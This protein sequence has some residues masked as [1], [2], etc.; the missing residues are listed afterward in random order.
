MPE[1]SVGSRLTLL[2]R[3]VKQLLELVKSLDAAMRFPEESPLGRELVG[4]AQRNEDE[5]RKL[6][7]KDAHHDA[8]IDKFNAMV[9][10]R[11]G[12]V[13]ALRMAALLLGI[14]VALLTLREVLGV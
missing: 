10:Q 14:I 1:A 7:E 11:D 5:I 2:E 3:D 8:E 6:K 13:R 9:D 4:R 12:V